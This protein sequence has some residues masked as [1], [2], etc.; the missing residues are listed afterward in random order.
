MTVHTRFYRRRDDYMIA[1]VAS[2]IARALDVDAWVIRLIFLVLVI[3]FGTGVLAYFILWMIMPLEKPGMVITPYDFADTPV[4]RNRSV[5]GVVLMLVG[6]YMLINLFF[7]PQVWRYAI[8][9]LL[10]VGGIMLF[11]KKRT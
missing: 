9:A 2:G 11:G 1:G 4:N 6:T 5:V 10:I 7:G 3:G 8:P